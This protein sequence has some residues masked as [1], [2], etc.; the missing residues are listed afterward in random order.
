MQFLMIDVTRSH[1]MAKGKGSDDKLKIVNELKVITAPVDIFNLWSQVIFNADHGELL[2]PDTME[3]F[4]E[5]EN[6]KQ[7]SCAMSREFF[8]V[9]DNLIVEDLAK[10]ATHILN[11]PNDKRQHAYP[12]VTIKAIWSVLDS[13]ISSKEWV[14]RQ[15]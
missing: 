6:W 5:K 12:K 7:D 14:E 15:K 3:K 11:E 8:K 4:N 2:D 1:K 9:L 10:L 13:C